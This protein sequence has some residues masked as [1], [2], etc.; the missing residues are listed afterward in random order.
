[1]SSAEQRSKSLGMCFDNISEPWHKQRYLLSYEWIKSLKHDRVIDFGGQ[2]P[3]TDYLKSLGWSVNN[4]E[5]DLTNDTKDWCIP[6]NH[7]LVLCME[8]IEHLKDP[9]TSDTWA[10]TGM[11]NMLHT[12]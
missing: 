1:M 3:F 2:S 4:T 10:F 9:D 8:V 11:R 7:D 5:H 6:L 12:A